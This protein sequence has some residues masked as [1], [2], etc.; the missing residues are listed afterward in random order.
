M[1]R[2]TTRVPVTKIRY[3]DASRPAPRADVVAVEEPLEIRAAGQVLTVTM[4][5]PGADVD[6]AHG[7]LLAEGLITSAAEVRTARYCAGAGET[8][9]DGIAQNTYNVLDLDLA[10]RALARLDGPLGA[11]QRLGV[12]T[13]ACGVCG[14]ASIDALRERVPRA[15]FSHVAQQLSVAAVPSMIET[16]RASQ[17][18]FGKTGGTHAA[19]LFDDSG[20]LRGA[21]EDVGRHNAVDKVVGGALV[22]G[23]VPPLGGTLV[24]SSRASYEVVQKAA[25]AGIP[26]VIAVSAPSS[27]AVDAATTLEMTL[28]AFAREDGVNVYAGGRRLND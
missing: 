4:R 11:A 6:L 23:A 15:G 9:P 13:S 16:L 26:V 14:S 22:S 12:T 28:L 10:D 20:A 3:A 24:V 17:A 25:M 21:A 8:G 1:G 5:T 27:L 19:A 18:T 2:V 7:W